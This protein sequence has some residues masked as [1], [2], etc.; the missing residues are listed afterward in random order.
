VISFYLCC[1]PSWSILLVRKLGRC[2]TS[3][4]P[5]GVSHSFTPLRNPRDTVSPQIGLLGCLLGSDQSPLLPPKGRPIIQTQVLTS[6]MGGLPIGSQGFSRFLV[7]PRLALQPAGRGKSL[8]WI[9][10]S[11]GAWPEALP[12]SQGCWVPETRRWKHWLQV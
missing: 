12:K 6:L 10:R 3:L 4:I 1:S 7:Q 5:R 9:N 11:T 8:P 2:S